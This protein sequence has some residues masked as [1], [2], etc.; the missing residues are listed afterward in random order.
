METIF[1]NMENSKKD[2]LHKFVLNFLRKFDLRSLN[3]LVALQKLSIHS[4]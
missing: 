4:T 2:E 1:M 3:K